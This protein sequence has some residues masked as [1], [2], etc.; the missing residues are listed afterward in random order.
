MTD[1]EFE[2]RMEMHWVRFDELR[3]GN[4]PKKVEKMQAVR[5]LILTEIRLR[6]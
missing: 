1:K 3:R 6:G 4:D 5:W 2:A